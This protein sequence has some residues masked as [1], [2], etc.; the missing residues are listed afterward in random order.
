VVKFQKCFLVPLHI[1]A[2]IIMNVIYCLGQCQDKTRLQQLIA[3]N[4]AGHVSHDRLGDDARSLSFYPVLMEPGAK[5]VEPK[6]API[7]QLI[8]GH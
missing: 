7:N 8:N 4:R 6:L 2:K 5:E 1:V 3:G